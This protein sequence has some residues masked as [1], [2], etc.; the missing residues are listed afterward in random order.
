M[1]FRQKLD[2]GILKFYAAFDTSK[3]ALTQ[4]DINLEDGLKF[5][6]NNNNFYLNTSYK[7]VLGNSWT[8][9]TGLSY[10]YAN[11]EIGIE[12]I[13]IND[14]ENSAHV[15]LKLKKRFNSRFK[16]S[17]GAEQFVTDFDEN[18]K[19]GSIDETLWVC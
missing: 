2:S 18:F 12:K 13:D 4:E 5:K 10:T 11:N 9:T 3:F 16:L 14:T 17:F 15:K 6:L 7:G 19:E 8:M 1:V